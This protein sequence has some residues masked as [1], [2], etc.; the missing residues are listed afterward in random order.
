[1]Q[2]H[3]PVVVV[4]VACGASASGGGDAL[5]GSFVGQVA[6]D[7]FDAFLEGREEDGFFVFVEALRDVPVGALGE[8][9]ASAAG[10]LEALVDEL[11]VIGVGE[12]AQVDL[13]APDAVAVVVAE[14]LAVPR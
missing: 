11:V 7:L 9:K 6:A 10:D 5:A 14:E 13:R 8:Q 12:K 4:A 3:L 2:S 1:M